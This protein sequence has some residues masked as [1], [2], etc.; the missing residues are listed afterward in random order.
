M[1]SIQLPDFSVDV[2]DGWVDR[3]VLVWSAHGTPSAVPPNVAIARDEM[4]PDESFLDYCN[5]QM[6]S[7]SSALD[8]FRLIKQDE[9][10]LS[11]RFAMELV[12]TWKTAAG[13]MKQ[14]QIFLPLDA[15]RIASFAGTASEADFDHADE[16]HFQPMYASLAI[17]ARQ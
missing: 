10:N 17:T 16:T 8:G 6:M 9:T 4:R 2:P 12:F 3:S 13:R 15:P 1:S 7:L 14:R 5:R 11:G